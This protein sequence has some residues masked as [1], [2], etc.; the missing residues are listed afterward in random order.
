MSITT[1]YLCV[2]RHTFTGLPRP[3]MNPIKPR[4]V[5]K[6]QSKRG[7][8]RAR[9][10]KNSGGPRATIALSMSDARERQLAVRSDRVIMSGKCV[11]TAA[12]VSGTVGLT[13]LYASTF[14]DRL[15]NM[16]KIFSRFR[17]IK[18]I[19]KS[20]PASGTFASAFGVVDD[21][22]G[23]GASAPL[24]TTLSEVV[25]L[26]CSVANLSTVNPNEIEWKPLD[27]MKVYY[28]QP[29]TAANASD[30]RLAVPATLVEFA[31]NAGNIPFVVYYTIEFSGA[32]D[33]T[34]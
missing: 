24:P 8:R 9:Q 30:S 27:P 5:P 31:A 19:I 33:N 22:T 12:G 13:P 26:R 6:N 34:A 3:C 28:S 10:N 25:E 23:E 15:A 4:I 21:Y 29:G 7:D 1:I 32:F 20:P 14:G 18:L 17:I 2:S 11:I 16:A